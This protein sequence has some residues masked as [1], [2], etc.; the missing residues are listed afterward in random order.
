MYVHVWL[1][2]FAVQQK[3]T[4]WYTATVVQLK[5]NKGKLM[6]NTKHLYYFSKIMIL[7]LKCPLI[8]NTK[9]FFE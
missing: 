5:K 9:Y 7:S 1:I 6:E 3:L 4:Q 8:P 2:H